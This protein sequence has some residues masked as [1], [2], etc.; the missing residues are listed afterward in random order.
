[1]TELEKIQ[2][3]KMYIEKMANGINPLDNTAA[4]EDDVINNIRVSRCLFYVSDILSKVIEN[5]GNILPS[6]QKEEKIYKQKVKKQPFFIT[7]EKLIEFPYST[8]AMTVTEIVRNINSLIDEE[9]YTKLKSTTVTSWLCDIGLLYEETAPSGKTVKRPTTQGSVSGIFTQERL[10]MNGVPYTA[11]VYT[12]EAQKFITDNI[13]ALIELNAVRKEKSRESRSWS[14]E[15]DLYLA[16]MFVTDVPI[17]QIAERLKR[18]PESIISRL[19]KLG[20]DESM[21]E[22]I[23]F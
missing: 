9:A 4:G 12:A 8:R 5:G 15:Q 11:V 1:M 13:D 19:K 10:S 21:A 6:E 23:K 18:T 22:E 14:K 20:F 17:M 2:R 3:A 16:D 7:A